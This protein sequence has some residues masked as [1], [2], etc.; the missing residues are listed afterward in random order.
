MIGPAEIRRILPHRHPMLLVDR[1]TDHADGE[2]L[3]AIKAVTSDEP[4]YADLPEDLDEQ[5][6][7]YPAVLV[8][9]SWCQSAGLLA[10]GCR[11]R[12]ADGSRD[13]LV[14]LFGGVSDVRYTSRVRPGDV[15]EHQ[16]RQVRMFSD[17]A[18]FEGECLVGGQP[19]MTVGRLLIAWRPLAFGAGLAAGH[20]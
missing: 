16:V 9:E 20:A 13:G 11:A 5:G 8:L 6:Y 1:V 17:T 4:W 10:A 2:R 12:P 14:M 3:A 7:D 18:I 15:L 19:V